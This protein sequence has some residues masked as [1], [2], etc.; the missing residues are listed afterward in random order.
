MVCVRWREME[1]ERQRVRDGETE[2]GVETE[3]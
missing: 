3:R 1:S 2:R